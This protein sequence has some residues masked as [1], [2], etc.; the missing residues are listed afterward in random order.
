[1]DKWRNKHK[2][3]TIYVIGSGKSLDFVSPKL[4]QNE[5]TIGVNQVYKRIPTTYLLR[6]EV[7]FRNSVLNDTPAATHHFWMGKGAS[8]QRVTYYETGV[9]H[10]HKRLPDFAGVPKNGLVASWSTLTTAMHLAAHMGAKTII[11]VGH[12]CCCIDNQSNFEGYHTR[13]TMAVAH[14]RDPKRAAQKYRRW[15][16]QIEKDTVHVRNHLQKTYGCSIFSLNP[17]VSL[18]FEGHAL[19]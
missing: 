9:N 16:P 7:H 1:M 3:E 15:L 6:K 5:I 18:R 13:D 17:F 4:F 11:L 10:C 12:D 14:G 2:G 19:S 8:T